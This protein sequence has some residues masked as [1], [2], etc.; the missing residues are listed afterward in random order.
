MVIVTLGVRTHFK[1]KEEKRMQAVKKEGQPAW[2]SF[3]E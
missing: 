1:Q 3:P 2:S